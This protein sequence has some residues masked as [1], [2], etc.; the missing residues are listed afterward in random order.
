MWIYKNV[1][2]IILDD[3]SEIVNAKL[4]TLID[5]IYLD[6]NKQIK[7]IEFKKYIKE[8]LWESN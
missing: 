3:D 6:E 7:H 1:K 5:C 2:N 8:L 4:K